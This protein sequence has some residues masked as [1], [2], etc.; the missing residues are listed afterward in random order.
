MKNDGTLT[1]QLGSD[2][3]PQ[4]VTWQ[5]AYKTTSAVTVGTEQGWDAATVREVPTRLHLKNQKN[6]CLHPVAS[7]VSPRL[8]AGPAGPAH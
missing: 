8:P 4:H 2:S 1:W 6:P 7:L 5:L 3:N